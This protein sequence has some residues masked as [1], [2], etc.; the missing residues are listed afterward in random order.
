MG[1]YLNLFA[2]KV[3]FGHL[4]L[5]FEGDAIGSLVVVRGKQNLLKAR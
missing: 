4:S 1:G 3:L 5:E 2:E